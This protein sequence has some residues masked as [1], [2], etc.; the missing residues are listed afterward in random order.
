MQ[1]LS[2]SVYD[3]ILHPTPTVSYYF[4]NS[5]TS[6]HNEQNQHEGPL[7]DEL[8]RKRKNRKFFNL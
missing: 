5:V 1:E 7:L 4:L 6:F 2:Q 3:A 8:A